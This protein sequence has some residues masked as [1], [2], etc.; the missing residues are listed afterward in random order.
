MGPLTMARAGADREKSPG[1]RAREDL[2]AGGTGTCILLAGT[3]AYT[4]LPGIA[5]EDG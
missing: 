5:R 2:D 1:G 3:S 4:Y